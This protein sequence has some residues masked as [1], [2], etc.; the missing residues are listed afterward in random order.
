MIA[1]PEISASP[2]NVT[3]DTLAVNDTASYYVSLFNYGT[4]NLNINSITSSSPHFIIDN[5]PTA[6]P[7][8]EFRSVKVKFKPN[9]LNQTFTS[10]LS[11]DNIDILITV[12]LTGY[13]NNTIGVSTITQQLPF[14]YSL[15]QNYPNPFNP[16]TKINYELR[17]T[18]YVSII[19]YDILGNKI[20]D[21]ISKKQNAGR[22]SVNFNASD[23]PSGVYYCKI[24]SGDFTETRKM[25]LLK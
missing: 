5:F 15:S 16:A 25:M 23:L 11:I 19:V 17:V 9:Q 8:R 1:K 20:S 2:F 21:L 18:N 3:F 14:E 6:V 24:I 12:N 22:H 7:Q 4:G 13:S 10:A